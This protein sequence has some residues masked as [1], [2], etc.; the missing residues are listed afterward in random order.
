MLDQGL[1]H[2]LFIKDKMILKKGPI[3]KKLLLVSLAALAKTQV[4]QPH[5]LISL[6]REM[7][8]LCHEQNPQSV[9]GERGYRDSTAHSQASPDCQVGPV[10]WQQPGTR[11]TTHATRP[12]RELQQRTPNAPSATAR[13]TWRTMNNEGRKERRKKPQ[14]LT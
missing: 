3:S 13:T 14:D 4:S 11:T 12:Q 9:S 1:P 5:R 8:A 6:Q 7:L 10:H 2:S